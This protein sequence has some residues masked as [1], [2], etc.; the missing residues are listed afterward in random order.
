MS[1]QQRKH[2]LEFLEKY[3][4]AHVS[5]GNRR[6]H[7]TYPINYYN[8]IT[9]PFDDYMD[10]KMLTEESVDISLREQD[11]ERLLDVLGYFQNHNNHSGYYQELETKL[12]FERQLRKNNP[13]LQKAY[14]KYMLMVSLTANGKEI[15]D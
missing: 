8:N 4:N 11:F 10:I 7:T 5:R 15:E 9:E 3:F 14:E 2:G 12:A 6:F 13:A 1:D